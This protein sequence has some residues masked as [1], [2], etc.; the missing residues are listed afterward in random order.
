MSC[1]VYTKVLLTITNIISVLLCNMVIAI[2]I[3]TVFNVTIRI[4][5]ISSI[6]TT[7]T[8]I[9]NIIIIII[10]KKVLHFGINQLS[11]HKSRR[12]KSRKF[13]AK[14]HASSM[15]STFKAI[16]NHKGY[17]LFNKYLLSATNFCWHLCSWDLNDLHYS[18]DYKDFLCLILETGE[19]YILLHGG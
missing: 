16:K 18:L 12:Q 11:K 14:I 2:N 3:T 19:H 10:N 15:W 8:I 1:L 13:Q 17:R 9:T 6:Q 7:T 4:A 5:I